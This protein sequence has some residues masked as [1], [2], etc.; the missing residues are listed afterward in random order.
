MSQSLDE[1]IKSTK[2]TGLNKN[3]S[4]KNQ[5]QEARRNSRNNR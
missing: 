3:Q 1:I 4:K 2:K 5:S